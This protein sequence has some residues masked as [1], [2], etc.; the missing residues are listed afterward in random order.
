MAAP[1]IDP[2]LLDV[3]TYLGAAVVAVPICNRLGL[4]SVIG[5]LVAGAAIGPFGLKFISEVTSVLHFAEFGVVL[6]L[7][8]IG[9]ELQPARLWRLRTEIF[10]L[11]LLQ[12]LITGA[13]LA[14]IFAGMGWFS[15]NAA[16]A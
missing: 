8:V 12:V 7:F 14:L 16:I 2:F 13:I 9:L 6:L 15:T 4:G 1:G 11:G 5:Y 3:A 10:G